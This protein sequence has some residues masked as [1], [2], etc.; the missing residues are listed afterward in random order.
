MNDKFAPK[1]RKVVLLGYAISQKGYKLLDIEYKIHFVSRDVK[2]HEDVFP[3]QTSG[4]G[5]DKDQGVSLSH[6]RMEDCELTPCVVFRNTVDGPATVT[7]HAVV[8]DSSCHGSAIESQDQVPLVSS[9]EPSILTTQLPVAT[10]RS[11]RLAKPLIWHTNYILSKNKAAGYCSYPITYVLDYQSITSAY[12]SFV[13]KFS[14]EKEH[15]SYH[16]A[17]Q[18][19]RWIT[20][21]QSEIQTLEDNH[22]WEITTLPK[23]KRV[24]GCK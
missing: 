3:F 11:N 18:D 6:S 2:F 21:M 22:T 8:T 12:R 1:A 9:P 23:D 10:R 24:I 19:P 20:A 15:A 13:T 17:I 7:Q 4:L 14:Q 5:Q 16:E